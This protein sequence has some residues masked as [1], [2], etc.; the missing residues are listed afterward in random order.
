MKYFNTQQ[1]AAG[2]VDILVNNPDIQEEDDLQQDDFSEA[3]WEDLQEGTNGLDT[4]ESS[5]NHFDLIANLLLVLREKYNLSSSAACLIREK[6]GH[7]VEQDRNMF[8]IKILS[9]LHKDENFVWSYELRITVHM[10]SPVVKSCQKFTGQQSLSTYI[11]AKMCF[12]K[13][14]K[15]QVGFNPLTA[16]ADSI[17]CVPIFENLKI[18]LSK[19]DIFVMDSSLASSTELLRCILFLFGNFIILP[20]TRFK[21][22]TL[23]NIKTISKKQLCCHLN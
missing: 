20:I 2:E 22:T 9:V 21:I 17:Q 16:K 15:L 3:P 14:N 13:P 5:V 11:K 1:A 4:D 10:V 23:S 8:A 18:L 19:K 12:V 7:L 6:L